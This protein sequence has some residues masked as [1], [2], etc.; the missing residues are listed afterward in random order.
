MLQNLLRKYGLL[1]LRAP[2]ARGNPQ[3]TDRKQ[4]QTSIA[5]QAD[6]REQQ[7]SG[8]G[9]NQQQRTVPAQG[10]QITGGERQD[11]DQQWN[12][13]QAQSFDRWHIVHPETGSTNSPHEKR[14]L[15]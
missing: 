14:Y 11:R 3:R 10:K 15:R 13:A 2:T 7:Q 8:G 1:D 9:R 5:D 6:D 12:S 4:G